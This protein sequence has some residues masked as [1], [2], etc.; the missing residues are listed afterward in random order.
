MEIRIMF[1]KRMLVIAALALTLALIVGVGAAAAQDAP[2]NGFG[3]G[4]GNGAGT[5][6]PG[7]FGSGNQN[8]NRTGD[9]APLGGRFA[10]GP[11]AQ[12][13]GYR[14]G[15]ND[16]AVVDPRG[17]QMGYHLP[18]AVVTELPPAIVDLMIDGW[19]DEQQAYAVYGAIIDQFGAVRPFT[20]IQRAEV[21]HAAAWETLF[22]RYGIAVPDVPDFDLP[23]YASLSEACAVGVEAEVANFG[24]YDAMLEA[25]APYPDLLH[26][27][28]TLRDV[29]EFNHLPAMQN[30]AAY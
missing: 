5:A 18:D 7:G 8:G 11:G 13:N 20:A 17:A 28:Q 12:G 4:V 19:L 22:A 23:T 29:S 30:C 1:N 15:W 24:L 21:Q 14:G 10:N 27:A 25:F 16:D 3:N 6:A 9:P 2:G 26:V